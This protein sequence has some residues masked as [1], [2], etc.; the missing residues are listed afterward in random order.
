MSGTGLTVSPVAG[1]RQLQA[2]VRF[3]HRLYRGNPHWVPPLDADERDTLR[4]DRNPAFA[5]C[6]ARLWLA[7]RDGRVVGRIAAIRN[8]LHEEKWGQRYL[9][10]G[11]VDFVDDPEVSAALFAAVEGWARECGATAVHGP[12]GF[13][14]MDREG[15][16]VEGFGERASTI[17]TYNHAYY[18]AHVET[19]GYVK[20]ADWLEYD[21]RVP[22]EPDEIIAR[23]AAVSLRRNRLHL[24]QARRRRDLLPHARELFQLLDDEYRDLYGV[25]PL[26]P[27][28][29]DRYIDQYLGFIRPEFVPIVL[30]E[31][32]RMVAFGITMPSLA[33][34][35]QRARGRL[36]P[37]G[38]LHLWRAL[39]RNSRAELCLIAVRAAYRGKGVNA[40]LMDCMHR[41]FI[42][43]GIRRVES[44]PELESN[45][46]VRGQWKHYPTRQHKRRRVYIKRLA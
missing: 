27:A 38:F 28:Q 40:I 33:R 42:R 21:L 37:F 11:W 39:R 13:S 31:N 41:L 46:D 17:T 15:M 24:L 8:R 20:D 23:I 35:L 2:F 7:W 6:Q 45:P 18:P 16:L 32:G 4:P 14:D 29:V 1:R 3:P 44:N 9:R 43:R 10:F 22:P 26:T 12:L 36:L 19:L 34:A 30:D 25:V 5:H